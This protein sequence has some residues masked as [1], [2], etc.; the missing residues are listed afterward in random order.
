MEKAI[1]PALSWLDQWLSR[2]WTT[3]PADYQWLLLQTLAT[4]ASRRAWIESWPSVADGLV[5]DL[6]CGPGIMAQEIAT[7]KSCRVVG[8]DRDA[9][10]LDMA[11]SLNHLLDQGA[12]VRFRV[13]DV[14]EEEGNGEANAV[15]S[16]FVTQYIPDLSRFFR[17]VKTHV[18]P[19]GFVAIEDVDDGYL[20]E[21][22]E[23][24]SAWKAA[25]GAFQR[26]QQGPGGDRFV[27]RKLA[28]AG[29]Q[30]GLRL[31]GVALNPSV[32][33]GQ[34]EMQDV[35]VQFDIERIDRVV[36]QMIQ[37]GLIT[38]QAWILAKSEYRASFPHF[39][40]VSSAT[41]RLLFLVP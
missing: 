22:P 15:V 25:V 14:L 17:Q 37:Q 19:G 40:Y 27:G 38:E 6:G 11:Q 29:V 13:A 20:I 7:L 10:I 34:M 24:P 8:Y 23:P 1:P 28:E 33:A 32:Y 3:A 16:R 4:A 26:Y 2:S 18:A 41:M 5:I 31:V 39:S 35:T 12:A 30:A 21:Y 9:V 36:P